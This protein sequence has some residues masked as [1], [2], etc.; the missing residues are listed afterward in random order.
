MALI[1]EVKAVMNELGDLG[2]RD[3]FARHGLDIAA[4]DLA[5]ELS[6]NLNGINRNVPGFEDFAEEG[7]R[8]IE[9]GSP[10]RSLVYHALASPYVHPTD[11][12]TPSDDEGDYPTIDHLDI[13]ENYIYSLAARSI[14]DFDEPI[15]AVMAYHYRTGLRTPH[16]VHAD[17][18]FSRTGVSRVG[19]EDM[20]YD[21]RRRSFWPIPNNA[22][23]VSVLPARFGIFIAERIKFDSKFAVLN[24]HP[25]DRFRTFIN[26]LHKVFPGDE[27]LVGETIPANS[28]D[29][30]EFHINEKLRKTHLANTPGVL[31][32]PIGL[33]PDEPPYVRESVE[34]VDILPIGAS[35][36]LV[37]KTPDDHRLVH[38][39]KQR[40]DQSQQDE[41]VRFTVPVAT[42]PNRFWTSFQIP[43]QANGR[44]APEYVNIRQRITDP[45]GDVNSL[46]DLN[47]LA[48][49]EF[50]NLL[51]NGGY[52]AAHFVDDCCDGTIV[53]RLESDSGS[54]EG[55]NSFAAYS[56]VT[57]PDFL[58]L[59]DQVDIQAWA[60]SSLANLRS[61]FSQGGPDP[62]SNGRTT[63]DSRIMGTPQTGRM[64]H[65]ELV[66]PN[67][68]TQMAF[69][70]NDPANLTITAVV[71]P[72]PLSSPEPAVHRPN[73]AVSFLPDAA[74]N[75]FAPGWD[76]SQHGDAQGEFYNAYGLGSPFPEDAKLCAALNSFWP[77]AAPDASRTFGI[78]FAPTSLPMLDDELGLHPDHLRVQFG[79]AISHRGWDGEFGPFLESGG[80]VVNF[81][82]RDRSDYTRHALDGRITVAHTADVD[83]DEMIARMEALRDCIRVLPAPM[84]MLDQVSDT[85][86]WLVV[87]EKVDWSMINN[88]LSGPGYTYEFILAGNTLPA[89][90]TDLSRSRREVLN[91]LICQISTNQIR[92]NLDGGSFQIVN[93]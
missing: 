55:L 17:M 85:R 10:A 8:G 14:G 74:S 13:V 90:P 4:A 12:G 43:G 18:A 65:P 73:I 77:A 24:C 29:Y 9:P 44:A 37:P 92:W 41:I 81:A 48:E 58:P 16:M 50:N 86:L 47:Q 25:D 2:W 63:G 6:R 49:E 62:L 91:H 60:D 34:L 53:A 45:T 64:P 40:N 93:R 19:T 31:A 22:N 59:T 69:D 83:S 80:N 72:A 27:C 5:T 84:M 3:M 15:V 54:L 42:G 33:R 78:Q 75:V 52:E 46:D 56:L 23:G 11:N 88:P 76:I 89:D 68:P 20:N 67:N 32:S 36:L 38:I 39:V 87:A 79:N 51:R 30:A 21:R 1:D 66:D 35:C 61:Q 26:P 57:A 71:G 28:F 7:E 82:N 70:R